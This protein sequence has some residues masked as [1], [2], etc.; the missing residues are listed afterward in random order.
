MSVRQI[1]LTLLR[2]NTEKAEGTEEA[3]QRK[4]CTLF[5]LCTLCFKK[6]LITSLRSVRPLR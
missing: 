4:L 3:S 1:M 2:L 5:P 6:I